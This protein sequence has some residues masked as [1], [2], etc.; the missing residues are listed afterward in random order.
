MQNVGKWLQTARESQSLSIEDAERET[1]I[2]PR[3]LR[4][5][6][7]GDYGAMP[8]GESQTRG[9]LRRYA[10]FLGLSP[11]EAITRY[12]QEVHGASPS[13]AA[14]SSTVREE[15]V[16]PARPMDLSP[17]NMGLWATLAVIGLVIF[18]V[19]VGWWLLSR[20]FGAA[21]SPSPIPSTPVLGDTPSPSSVSSPTSA[22][23]QPSPS[24]EIEATPTFAVADSVTVTLQALEHVW[25][26]VRVDEVV[27]FEGMLAP[28]APQTWI[29]LQQVVVETGNGAGLVA[30]ANGQEQGPIGERGALSARGWGP[31]GEIVVPLPGPS[32]PG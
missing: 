16:S 3:Y 29:G 26:R 32:P 8:G 17:P 10:A 13:A 2:R 28:D 23:L 27:V 7:T 14:P 22:G 31:E 5:L 6:E 25:I 20:D 24:P 12:D 9:F 21:P 18:L 15:I 19:L 30:M 4:A 1:R 11:D